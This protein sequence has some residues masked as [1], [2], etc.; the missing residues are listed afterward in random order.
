MVAA[1]HQAWLSANEVGG[2]M[3][4]A[5]VLAGADAVL[6]AGVRSVTGLE[7]LGVPGR[8]VGG[9]QLVA[10]AVGF[11][12][13]R[14]LRPGRGPFA[15]ADD[16]H[17]GRPVGQ[18]VPAGGAAQQPGQLG[19]AGVVGVA[20]LA[21]VVEHLVP[22]GVGELADR[23]AAAVV[24]VEPDRVVH[25]PPGCGVQRGDVVDQVQG[26]ARTV[27]GDQQVPPVPGRELRDR[28]VEHL[29]VI[30][31]GVASRRCPGAAETPTTRWCCHT[32][33]SASGD[34][35]CP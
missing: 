20:G 23:G 35:R 25:P 2:Q 4:D 12:H 32:T 7:E 8:G 33:R 29:D 21:A 30:D 10:P 11:F 22:V 6:H 3:A 31:R 1:T 5:G 16:A 15:A 9:D 19:H 27:A 13:Q 26:G 34:P 17:V 14:Q 18:P 24:E 28:L